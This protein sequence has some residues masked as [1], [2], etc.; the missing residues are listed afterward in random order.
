VV[1]AHQLQ[2]GA[3]V[4]HVPAEAAAEGQGMED[5]VGEPFHGHGRVRGHDDVSCLP[6]DR[7]H[8]RPREETV[9]WS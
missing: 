3:D 5:G 1:E 6:N 4:V 8:A 2:V 7:V 9:E